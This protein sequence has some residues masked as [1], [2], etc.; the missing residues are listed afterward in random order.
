[1]I[2]EHDFRE[3]CAAA[4]NL[5]YQR[6]QIL[7]LLLILLPSDNIQKKVNLDST[8]RDTVSYL[9]NRS[10]TPDHGVQNSKRGHGKH[11]KVKVT[12]LQNKK[13]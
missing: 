10:Q 6:D 4:K 3:L 8:A 12:R 2:K 5:P 13:Y 11:Y 7:L 9:L 1:M